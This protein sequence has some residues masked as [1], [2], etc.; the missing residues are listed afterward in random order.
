[1]AFVAAALALFGKKP[2]SNGNEEDGAT[3]ASAPKATI[4]VIDDDPNFL[5]TMR[6]L[7]RGAGYTVLA[8]STGP[9]GLDM[10]RYA[11]HGVRMV[12]LDFNMPGF[13]GAETLAYLRKLNPSI[14]V[15]AVSGFKVNELPPDFRNGVDGFVAKPF[16]NGEL[17]EAI[18]TV[19]AEGTKAEVS[20]SA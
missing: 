11:P 3:E 13:S 17:L 12:L 7:L 19:L 15:I 8:S 18:K 16:S 10:I 4:L 2:H 6:V 9:K 5:D 14:K 20:V 1:M